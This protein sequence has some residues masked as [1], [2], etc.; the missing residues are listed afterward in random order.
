MERPKIRRKIT[1]EKGRGLEK[2]GHAV[3]YL[4]DEF[5][6]N[7]VWAVSEDRG[8]LDAIQLLATL[9]REL[10]LECGIEP[11]IRDRVR[12]LFQKQ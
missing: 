8:R 7:N 11:T 12:A 2:L 6:H 3:A 1:P 10:Y 4:E 9:S 5:V